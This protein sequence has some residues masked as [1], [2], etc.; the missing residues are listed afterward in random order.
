MATLSLIFSREY[1]HFVIIITSSETEV[2]SKLIQHTG[3][4]FRWSVVESLLGGGQYQVCWKLNSKT[5]LGNFEGSGL[6]LVIIFS[7]IL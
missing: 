3:H 7:D 4:I 6:F 2:I 5:F 1:A